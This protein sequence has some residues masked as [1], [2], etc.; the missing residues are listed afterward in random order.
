MLEYDV[1]LGRIKEPMPNGVGHHVINKMAARFLDKG[2]LLYYDNFFSSVKPASNLLEKK[3]CTCPTIQKQQG[4]RKIMRHISFW[5]DVLRALSAGRSVRRRVPAQPVSLEG[6]AASDPTS[7]TISYLPS[8]CLWRVSQHQTPCPT[9]SPSIL[10]A[11]RTVFSARMPSVV[12]KRDT[13]FSQTMD[14]FCALSTQ[15]SPM[16]QD[17]NATNLK[18]RSHVVDCQTSPVKQLQSECISDTL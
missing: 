11:S 1:Y 7:H 4:Q 2:H 18:E 8:L 13:P 6:V 17:A 16:R 12:C 15:T 9:Q 3:T 5:L 14:V 10:A